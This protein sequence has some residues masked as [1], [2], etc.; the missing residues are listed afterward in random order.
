[1]SAPA[2][3]TGAVAALPMDSPYR[4]LPR[5]S[6][7]DSSFA[8]HL[9]RYGPPP[10]VS[11]RRDSLLD[12]V[13][14]S[15]LSGRGGAGFPT[16]VKLRTVGAR[17]S[18]VVVANGTEGEPASSK[19]E[20]LLTFNPHLVIDGVLAALAAVGSGEAYLAVSRR[21]RSAHAALDAALAERRRETERIELVSVPD[22]FVAGEE[23]AL[24]H[25][26]NGGDA[27]PTFTPPRPFERGVR[28]RPTLVQNV[29]TLANLGLIAR[30]GGDWFRERGTRDEPGTALVTVRGAVARP[31]VIE[32]ELGT[33]LG[34]IL[35]RCGGLTAPPRA[36]LVGGYFGSWIDAAGALDVPLAEAALQPRGAALGAR[37]LAVLPQGTCGV[38]ETARI[39]RYLAGESAGQCGP[40][41]F[42]L[43]AVAQALEGIAVSAAD[44]RRALS[45]LPQLAEQIAR[46]GACGH[47]D[48]ALR[49][50]DSALRVFAPE[51]EL[52]LGGRCTAGHREPL[53][54]TA[55]ES[56]DWR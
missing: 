2:V 38:A 54:P 50:V 25:W 4:L 41:V 19:D 55:Q 39:A 17:R 11:R 21:A 49:L 14:R 29:E 48:G 23:S 6:A 53:L 24:V 20:V 47:P 56:A 34:R 18:P 22:R 31:G 27:K 42:G 45:R 3:R 26:L 28:G 46:R 40:C 9:D 35:D 52:H 51:I 10:Q 33:P 12:E 44:A 15:G 1:V 8:A 30:Y 32:A 16:A 43:P 37:T 13:E 36:L 7:E 5:G